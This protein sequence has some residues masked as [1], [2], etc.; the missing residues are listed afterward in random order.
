MKLGLINSVWAQA[1][2]DTTAGIRRTK[3]IGFDAIDIFADPLEESAA[4]QDRIVATCRELDLPI[5]SVACVALGLVDPNPSVRRFHVDRVR[6]YLDMARQFDA[7]N[8]L[9][10]LGSTSGRRRSSR[11][12][13]SGIT[14]S[15]PCAPSATMPLGSAWRSPWSWSR[16]T[17]RSSNNVASMF[18][19]LADVDRPA[20][21]ANLDI[22]HL[23]LA[24]ETADRANQLRGRVAHVH[25]SDCDGAVHG[26]L[27]PGRG[28]VDFWPYLTMINALDIPDATISI[29]LEFPPTRPGRRVGDRGLRVDRDPDAGGGP[30]TVRGVERWLGPML[31]SLAL[32]LVV[33]G[34]TAA[35][36]GQGLGIGARADA[37][38]VTGAPRDPF[39]A[40]RA[41]EVARPWGLAATSLRLIALTEAIALPAGLVLGFV[42]FRTDAWGR[43]GMLGAVALAAFVPTP[44]LATGWLG[45]FG[46]AGRSQA[47]GSGPVLAGL[48]GAAFI[49]AM[50]ALPWVV[51]IAGVGFRGV[52]PDLEALARLDLP[53]LGV[54]VRV[55]LRRSLGAIF[56]AALAVAV[57]TGGDMTVT[58]LLQV[59]TYAEEAYTQYQLG[60][61]GRAAAVALPPLGL[62]GA[63]ILAGMAALLRVDPARVVSAATRA[64]DWPLGRWRV[65]VGAAL[66]LSAGNLVA[67]PAYSLLWRAGRVGGRAAAGMA[68]SWSLGGLGGTLRLA[69]LELLGAGP[70]RP[71]RSPMLSSLILAGASAL[72]A[73]ALAWGLAVLARRSGAWRLATALVVALTLAVP[74]PVA[75]MALVVAYLQWPVIYDTPL[76]VVLALVGR[77]LPYATLILWPTIRG[78]P[79]AYLD[80]AAVAGY[81]AFGRGVRVLVPL[82]RAAA[83]AAWGVAFALALGELPASNLVAPPGTVLLSVRIWELLHTGVES[84]LAGVGLL[85]LVILAGAGG[86]AAWAAGRAYRGSAAGPD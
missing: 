69:G 7:R 27:P 26:D 4:E 32:A 62:L 55:T 21:R 28:V 49:H 68:P 15:R 46:N 83:L 52:E 47:L 63:L 33:G 3:E 41:G 2:L 40:P 73:V 38:E 75:G 81:G 71:F 51:I 42:L 16:S 17:S 66:I 11:P 78:V 60:N 18:R 61:S 35:L 37:D 8:V 54:I 82:T 23:A 72:G 24:R 65:P 84:H 14:A 34:P 22:S 12:P 76:I 29:E 79:Q 58:D 86:L 30:P 1:G 56:A 74:G 6:A 67:L 13:S 36:V 50:A 80:E 45:G 39:V 70:T 10:V 20:V 31:V 44:L 77:T 25:I 19:F 53:P 64:R 43:R 5:I 48:P 59:R 85:V 9:L 57:L